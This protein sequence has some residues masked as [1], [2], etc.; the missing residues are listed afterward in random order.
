MLSTT[1]FLAFCARLYSAVIGVCKVQSPTGVQSATTGCAKCNPRPHC[2][3]CC[4]RNNPTARQRDHGAGR[5]QSL[6]PRL[7]RVVLPLHK[8]GSPPHR[9]AEL[10]RLGERTCGRR[11]YRLR[12]GRGIRCPAP[13]AAAA[14]AAGIQQR[15][16][17]TTGRAKCN[18]HKK[19]RKPIN[20]ISGLEERT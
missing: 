9:F 10:P 18:P 13:T 15:V 8:G 12:A 3:S 19:G 6:Q 4:C 2:G 17:A 14:A 7:R 20:R 16:S 1:G 5:G 11:E